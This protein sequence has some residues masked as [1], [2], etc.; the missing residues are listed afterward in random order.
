MKIKDVR[1]YF[2]TTYKFNKKTGMS[3]SSLLNWEKWGYIPIVS[4]YKLEKL[5]KGDLKA[6]FNDSQPK[7]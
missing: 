3:C 7:E 4:Q 2:G 5:T 1:E 6:N